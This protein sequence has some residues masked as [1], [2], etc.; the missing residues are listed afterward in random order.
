MPRKIQQISYLIKKENRFGDRTVDYVYAFKNGVQK[1]GI[2]PE[3][4]CMRGFWKVPKR[5]YIVTYKLNPEGAY[6]VGEG[7]EGWKDIKQ[8]NGIISPFAICLFPGSWKKGDRFDRIVK[9]A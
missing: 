3:V 9:L 2:S 7:W 1:N 5:S 4:S 8:V 6:E